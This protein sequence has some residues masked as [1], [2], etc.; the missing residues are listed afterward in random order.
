MKLHK[1]RHDWCIKRCSRVSVRCNEIGYGI[2]ACVWKQSPF[3][4]PQHENRHG[5]D[6][7]VVRY[8]CTT[9][10]AIIAYQPLMLWV[11]ISLRRGVL[12][13]ILC[14]KVCQWLAAGL[15]FSLGTPD[16]HNISETVLKATLNIITLIHSLVT[17][18]GRGK[19]KMLSIW[20]KN[21]FKK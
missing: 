13:T 2:A 8:T 15:W 20:K 5:R 19:I 11:R 21:L 7:M 10:Y 1:I 12:D 17:K 9:T 18:F 4:V 6:C 16:R 14:D 3:I